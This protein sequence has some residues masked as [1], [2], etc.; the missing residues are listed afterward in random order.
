MGRVAASHLAYDTLT[1]PPDPA[2]PTP[3]PSDTGTA[4]SCL[5]RF[6]TMPFMFCNINN[7]CNFAS[8][9]D[10]SYW[11]STPEPMPSSM[12]PI[13]GERIKPFISR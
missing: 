7:V 6:S 4:G 11:L 13:T 9:N 1:V 10:Y 5:R 12:A 2:S 3:P 8:R